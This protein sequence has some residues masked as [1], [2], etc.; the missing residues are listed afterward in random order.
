MS[1]IFY[2]EL[3][4]SSFLVERNIM[5]KK[6]FQKKTKIAKKKHFF[7]ETERL[8]VVIFLF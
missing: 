8:K 7:T 2:Y 4:Q 6:Q 1:S 3:A 5:N